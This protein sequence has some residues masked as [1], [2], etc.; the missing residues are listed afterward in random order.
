VGREDDAI[1]REEVNFF[2]HH[3]NAALLVILIEL[4]RFCFKDFNPIMIAGCS[5]LC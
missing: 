3:D 4:T 5:L 1:P 2:Q